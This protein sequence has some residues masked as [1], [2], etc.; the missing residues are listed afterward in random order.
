MYTESELKH[1]D[2]PRFVDYVCVHDESIEFDVDW[3]TVSELKE[4]F[5]IRLTDLEKKTRIS[6]FK[7]Q[8]GYRGW[9]AVYS[10]KEILNYRLIEQA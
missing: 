7:T 3:W 10:R 9:A 5:N 6:A 4:L 2:V 8:E 1:F